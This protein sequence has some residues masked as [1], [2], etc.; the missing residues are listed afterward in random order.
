MKARTP[1][2]TVGWELHSTEGTSDKFY[3]FL[4]A[5]TK[6]IFTY[7]ARGKTGNFVVKHEDSPA[8]ALNAAISQ[9][10]AKASKGYLLSVNVTPFAMEP[11]DYDGIVDPRSEILPVLG[12]QFLTTAS[13]T[14]KALSPHEAVDTADLS[15]AVRDALRSMA[16]PAPAAR[17]VPVRG[18]RGSHLAAVGKCVRRNGETYHPRVVGPH[19]DVA[20]LRSAQA[21]REPVLLSGPPGTGK[22]ALLEAAFPESEQLVGSAD[23]AEA[24]LLGTWVQDPRTRAFVWVAGPLLRSVELDVPFF[25]DEIALID[26]RVLSVVYS[27]MDGRGELRVTANPTLA[28]LR[29]GPNWLLVGAYNPDVPG[30]AL[31][32]ALSDRFEHHIEVGTDFELARSLGVPDA[33]VAIALHLDTRRREGEISWSPQL[34]S[35]LAFARQEGRYGTDYAA[36]ALL[37]KAPVAD[38]DV[39]AD[40]LAAHYGA[41]AP[42]RLGVRHG[43]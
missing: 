36:A 1:V 8:A 43:V 12:Q 40:A 31:S 38:R 13:A 37:T 32:E 23:T 35:L 41:V 24:D 15:A 34:R 16:T 30:A 33:L 27:L 4:V 11:T 42:L 17:A 21:N 5:G 18:V 29:V 10:R 2:P 39:V 28:P 7:G 26:P 22:T 6:A 20:L 14:G 9:T 3:R 19:E 25:V